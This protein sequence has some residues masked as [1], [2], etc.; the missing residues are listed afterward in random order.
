MRPLRSFSQRLLATGAQVRAKTDW[1][2]G[3]CVELQVGKLGCSC[4]NKAIN[5][6]KAILCLHEIRE[7]L[8]IKTNRAEAVGM[9]ASGEKRV[10]IRRREETEI[11]SRGTSEHPGSQQPA[12]PWACTFSSPLHPQG[13]TQTL[14]SLR[15]HFQV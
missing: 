5:N 3:R 12:A 10:W 11:G 13:P 2:S 7:R 15:S 6:N 1:K 9:L 14:D 4:H 8:D